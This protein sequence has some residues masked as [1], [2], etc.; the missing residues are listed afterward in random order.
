[1][2][3]WTGNKKSVYVTLGASNH[4]SEDRAEYDYYATEPK[5]TEL[6]IEQVNLS[7][8]LEP[9]C[10]GG[11]M[12]KV[13]LNNGIDVTSSDII[14]RN[15]GI[16]RDFFT[17]D[18]WDGDIVTNPPYKYAQQFV[19]HAIK[20]VTDNHKVCM[21]LKLQFLEGQ[22]RK[23]LFLNNPPQTVYVSS[24]RLKC[25]KNGNFSQTN[26]SAVAFAWFVW[27]KGK[28]VK[29]TIEWIN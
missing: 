28:K 21:L 1:M 27:V 15:F 17:Y 11:H 16:I 22:K 25:A 24:S 29:T 7:N 12:S 4:V 14:Y 18:Y 13:L 20:I 23:Q 5:A 26:S 19:E 9:A 6:L 10:G 3:D 8:V 2:K